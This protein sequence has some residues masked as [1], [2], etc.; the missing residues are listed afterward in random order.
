MAVDADAAVA[1]LDSAGIFDHLGKILDVLGRGEYDL[2]LGHDEIRADAV[3]QQRSNLAAERKRARHGD[4]LILLV[5]HIFIH[6]EETDV[7]QIQLTV[8]DF[9]RHETVRL[10]GA[11]RHDE[12]DDLVALGGL[13]EFVHHL[14]GEIVVH[15]IKGGEQHELPVGAFHK[16]VGVQRKNLAYFVSTFVSGHDKSPFC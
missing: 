10:G 7:L 6:E 12:A 1:N 16:L 14:L 13:F 11:D 3:E 4:E 15:L 2:I 9:F 5:V 8:V